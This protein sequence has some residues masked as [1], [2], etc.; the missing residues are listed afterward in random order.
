[1]QALRERTQ[2]PSTAPLDQEPVPRAPYPPAPAATRAEM[3]REAVLEELLG[4]V[5]A[6]E[7]APA[8]GVQGVRASSAPSEPVAEVTSVGPPARLGWPGLTRFRERHRQL[9]AGLIGALSVVGV[10]VVLWSLGVGALLAPAQNDPG[11]LSAV[12]TR[13][14]DASAR[15]PVK[16]RAKAAELRDAPPSQAPAKTPVRA[17]KPSTVPATPD[18]PKLPGGP[19]VPEAL[20]R[21]SWVPAP[22][23]TGYEIA[24]YSGSERVISRRTLSATVELTK[25]LASGSYRWYVWAV[26]DN[27]KD[28]AAIVSATLDIP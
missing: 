25:P 28:D 10:G 24:I 2:E 7:P 13:P 8:D 4:L 14:P 21:L 6:A 9:R 20:R 18:L 22:G 26:R 16:P 3:L 27:V 5:R 1:M 17:T 19:A 15:Q 11:D 12:S 23:A